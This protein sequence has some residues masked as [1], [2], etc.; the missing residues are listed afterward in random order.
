MLFKIDFF[1]AQ[2]EVVVNDEENSGKNVTFKVTIKFANKVDMSQLLTYGQSDNAQL[3]QEA[4]QALDV[5]LRNPAA[6]R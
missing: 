1:Q 6:R 5:V 4:I 2:E 3:P